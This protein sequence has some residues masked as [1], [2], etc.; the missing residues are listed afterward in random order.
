M[1]FSFS[2]GKRELMDDFVGINAIAKIAK[3][4]D[5]DARTAWLHLLFQV[6][7]IVLESLFHR[8]LRLPA[9]VLLRT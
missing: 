1:A 2:V 5:R 6:L 9:Q 7:D 8:I 4:N 3:E